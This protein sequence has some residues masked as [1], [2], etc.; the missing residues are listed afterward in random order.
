M[1]VVLEPVVEDDEAFF[2]V[3]E[4][5]AMLHWDRESDDVAVFETDHGR[6]ERYEIHESIYTVGIPLAGKEISHV[7][8]LF[9][10]FAGAVE[11]VQGR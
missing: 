10:G 11:N 9:A 8:D 6:G 2:L 3:G 7:C 1:E 4:S 5:Y